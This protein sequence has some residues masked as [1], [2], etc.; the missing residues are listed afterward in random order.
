MQ[1]RRAQRLLQGDRQ[2]RQEI[3]K[4]LKT[5]SPRTTKSRAFSS[6]VSPGEKSKEPSKLV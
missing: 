4:I 2:E 5:A 6:T 3:M 1:S